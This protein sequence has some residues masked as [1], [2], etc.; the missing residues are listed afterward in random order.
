MKK[1]LEEYESNQISLISRILHCDQIIV[2]EYSQ[3]QYAS[4]NLAVE[5][6][7]ILARTPPGSG[8]PDF[9]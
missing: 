3:T 8:Y 7:D 1:G 9:R 4:G 2:S 5:T 6:L